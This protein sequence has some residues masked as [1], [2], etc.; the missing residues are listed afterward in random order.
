MSALVVRFFQN[1]WIQ[2]LA[3]VDDGIAEAPRIATRDAPAPRV[4]LRVAGD[5]DVAMVSLAALVALLDGRVAVELANIVGKNAGLEVEAVDV[6]GDDAAE[7]ATVLEL[8]D[9]HVAR[10]WL[11]EVEG[12]G[13]ELALAALGCKGP[14]AGGGA[15]VADVAG[16]RE[17]GAGK[18]D[19]LVRF[20]DEFGKLL[21]F[22]V[23]FLGGHGDFLQH[24]LVTVSCVSHDAA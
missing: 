4:M 20:L 6:L 23:E 21:G 18:K 9:G 19:D 12:D 11:R 3:E 7:L 10:V 2:I 17:A 24:S 13:L 22:G 16:G 15:V 5:A 14:E 8:D 1:P